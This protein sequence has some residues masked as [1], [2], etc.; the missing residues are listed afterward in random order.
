MQFGASK[1]HKFCADTIYRTIKGDVTVVHAIYNPRYIAPTTCSFMAAFI[2]NAVSYV[3]HMFDSP[4][5]PVRVDMPMDPE[6]QCYSLSFTKDQIKEYKEVGPIDLDILWIELN[7]G[8][9]G[10][11]YIYVYRR[12]QHCQAGKSVHA[13][14]NGGSGRL[15]NTTICP[16]LLR[17][18]PCSSLRSMAMW[19]YG[20]S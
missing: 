17:S 12:V 3:A 4:Y 15:R 2:A 6:E 8:V 20:M 7:Y 1:P 16:A 14:Y 10:K 18:S 13:V 5:N 9:R 11:L 19:W